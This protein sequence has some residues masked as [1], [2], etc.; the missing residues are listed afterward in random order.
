[1]MGSRRSIGS[2]PLCDNDYSQVTLRPTSVPL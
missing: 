1:M 2:D